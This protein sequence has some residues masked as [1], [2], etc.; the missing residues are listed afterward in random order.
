MT[1]HPDYKQDSVVSEEINYDLLKLI[2]EKT[3]NCETL[4]TDTKFSSKTK[5]DIPTA[6]SKAEKYLAQKNP[7]KNMT[8]GHKS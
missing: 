4:S 1:N 7:Q 6:L 5:D 8:N 3:D 2:H